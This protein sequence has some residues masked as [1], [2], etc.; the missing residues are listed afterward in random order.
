MRLSLPVP[1]RL[2]WDRAPKAVD[3]R[4]EVQVLPRSSG[5][6]WIDHLAL[7]PETVSNDRR[8]GMRECRAR[9]PK[10]RG[11]RCFFG[12]AEAEKLDT[13][14]HQ[15]QCEGRCFGLVEQETAGRHTMQHRTLG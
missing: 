6:V 14:V 8:Q 13:A 2:K 11:D 15:Q 4:I 12:A 1:F 9:D 7:D 3:E 10:L 5:I